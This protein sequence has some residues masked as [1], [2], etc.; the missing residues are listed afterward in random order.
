VVLTEPAPV[1]TGS[2][3]R[4]A[5]Q[6]ALDGLRAVAVSVVVLYHLDYGWMRGGFMG[7]D[8]F[9]V[10]SGFLI[11]SLLLREW[12]HTDRVHFGQFWSRRARRLLPAVFLMIAFAAVY[13]STI[14]TSAELGSLRWDAVSGVLYYANWHFISS[15]QSYFALFAAPSPLTHL[16][17]LAIEEQFYL[18][19]PVVFAVVAARGRL[20]AV[21]AVCVGGIVVS[22]IVMVAMYDPANPS[23]A[24][25]ATPARLN[26]LLVG[27]ALAVLLMIRPD[28]IRRCSRA[29]LTLIALV[30]LAMCTVAW[31]RATASRTF[32][33]GGDTLFALAFAALLF[34]FQGAR[35]PLR[36]VFELRPLVWLGT[37]SYGVYLW[38][39]PA[40]VF[41]TEDRTGLSG[42][43]LDVVRVAV[44]LAV[45]YASIRLL[46]RPV[47]HSRGPVL[48]WVLPATAVT[49]G[50]ALVATAGATGPPNFAAAR[51][52]HPCPDWGQADIATASKVITERGVPNVPALAGKNITVIGDS[53]ACSLVVG[54]DAAASLAGFTAGNGAVLGC[55]VVAERFDVSGLIP[56][57]W[58]DK[59]PAAFAAAFDRVRSHA[60]VLVW[61]SA[62]EGEDLLVGDRTIP[63]DDPLHD[64]LLRTRME[65]W[66]ATQ[67]PPDVQVAIVLTPQPNA[68]ANADAV[69]HPKQLNRVYEG[70]AAAHPDR[71]HLLDLD[72]FLCPDGAPCDPQV[73]GQ[74]VRYDGTHLSPAGAGLVARWMLPQLDAILRG[75]AP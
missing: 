56:A 31:V 24:Y 18:V 52:A 70:F 37:I 2:S 46:E 53:R 8:A 48:R 19:W 45:S 69:Q 12:R 6:P 74:A 67:V 21:F 68:T 73:D 9:F 50:I 16:W 72:R 15:G 60:N 57:V 66:L 54:F 3:A 5:Y 1:R 34:A 41:L 13:G 36:W 14:V 64:L 75:T 23:R 39:W 4:F 22:Q 63:P 29:L 55:G 43:T 32:F 7:V 26:T 62:W 28:L 33:W 58:R 40:I 44:T 30:A 47:R 71:V 35:T 11:T 59:C 51:G 65:R 10:L 20:R 42:R 27:C 61:W 38:H 17:S 49:L 25:Y